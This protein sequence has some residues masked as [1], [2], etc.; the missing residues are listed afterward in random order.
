MTPIIAQNDSFDAIG[1]TAINGVT[2]RTC[3][4]R[5]VDTIVKT[6]PELQSL[7]LSNLAGYRLRGGERT[8]TIETFR[9]VIAMKTIVI[10]CLDVL[11]SA[12][13]PKHANVPV[14]QGA[15]RCL[16]GQPRSSEADLFCGIERGRDQ[17]DS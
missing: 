3:T 14:R 9:P 8:V 12:I 15:P 4:N 2:G 10:N 6:H 7:P 17:A 1:S 5:R 16:D 11:I 13:L